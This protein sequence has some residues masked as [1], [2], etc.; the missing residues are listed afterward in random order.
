[1]HAIT[2]ER[3]RGEIIKKV[4]ELRKERRW[5]Q[6]ELA[7]LL[8]LSQNRL[9]EIEHGQGS[10]TAE[11]LLLILKTFNIPIDYFFPSK[12]KAPEATQIQNALARLG[13][14]HLLEVEAL[15]SERF[16]EALD[17]IREVLVSGESPRHVAAIAQVIVTQIQILNLGK[18]KAQLAE[19][20][21]ER[22]L[23]WALEN[24]L[25]AV[26]YELPKVLSRELRV[27]YGK[28]ET[29]LHLFLAPW[30]ATIS[31]TKGLSD[32]ILDADIVS[33][34]A[35]AEVRAESSKISRRWHIVTRIKLDDFIRALRVV[36]GRS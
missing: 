2:L 22:R 9:S 26:R 7:K 27:H 4:R 24:T 29:I 31:V 20:G 33:E 25:E 34:Q 21:F 3:G 23:G 5:T 6:A 19:A 28:V 36:R 10:F 8:G 12:G 15:P 1:M 30:I 35:V 18:L 16:A 14:R 13:A 17:V 32:D 11:Q